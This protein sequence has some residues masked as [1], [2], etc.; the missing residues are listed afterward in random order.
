MTNESRSIALL[1]W[2]TSL[3]I[4]LAASACSKADKNQAPPASP[5]TIAEDTS[6]SLLGIDANG[7]GIRDDIEAYIQNRFPNSARAR[8]V[9]RGYAKGLQGALAAHDDPEG[10][11]AAAE[12]KHRAFWCGDTIIEDEL[13]EITKEL[14]KRTFNTEDRARAYLKFLLMAREVDLDGPIAGLEHLFCDFDPS[15]MEN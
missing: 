15:A 3:A 9:S 8:E 2:I 7:D 6:D 4:G 13:D 12:A 14:E 10:A 11:V 5:P 1:P